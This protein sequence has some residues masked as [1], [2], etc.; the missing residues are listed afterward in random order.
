MFFY[1]DEKFVQAYPEDLYDQ[2]V[3]KQFWTKHQ[4]Y[5]TLCLS[6][7]AYEKEKKRKK[8]ILDAKGIKEH[9]YPEWGPLLLVDTSAAI[10]NT[11]YKTAR[12]RLFGHE[13]RER[14]Q[15]PIEK[16]EDKGNDFLPITNKYSEME[17]TTKVIATFWLRMARAKLQREGKLN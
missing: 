5:N 14:K 8:S 11:W 7:L 3:F 10:L 16:S 13:G 15:T 17:K 6:C 9:N 2:V 4:K 1:R 12:E